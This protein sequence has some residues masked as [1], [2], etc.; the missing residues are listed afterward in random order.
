MG[1]FFTSILA[2]LK[3]IS[4]KFEAIFSWGAEVSK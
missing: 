4:M 1:V 3:P 2:N